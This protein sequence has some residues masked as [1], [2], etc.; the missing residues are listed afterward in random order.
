MASAYVL[1]NVET[2]SGIEVQKKL[3][4]MEGVIAYKVQGVYD[5][6]AKVTADSMDSLKETINWRIRRVDK[7]KSTLT[8]IMSEALTI[9]EEKD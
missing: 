9:M 2:G 1:I 7:V 5:L 4:C 8:M 6:V 3:A